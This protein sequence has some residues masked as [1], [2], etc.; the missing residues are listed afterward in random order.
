VKI[1]SNPL[2]Y[3]RERGLIEGTELQFVRKAPL[4]DPILFSARGMYFA[5]RQSELD[6][7]EFEDE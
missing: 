3:L 2:E 4:G 5:I 1:K 6:E 7:M